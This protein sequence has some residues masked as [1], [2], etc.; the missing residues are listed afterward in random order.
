[1][2]FLKKGFGKKAMFW[3]ALTQSI[4]DMDFASSLWLDISG[5]VPC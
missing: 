3:G 4:P 5:G 1:M 2:R